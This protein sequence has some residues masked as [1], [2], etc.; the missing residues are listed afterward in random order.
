MIYAKPV[1]SGE[2]AA[3]ILLDL[4]QTPQ[5]SRLKFEFECGD[6]QLPFVKYTVERF[7][8]DGDQEE[9]HT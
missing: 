8:V 5:L 1:Q 6:D 3:Q 9:R 2:T 4:M 7:A